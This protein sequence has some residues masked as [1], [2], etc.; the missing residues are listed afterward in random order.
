MRVRSGLSLMNP[1]NRPLTS[2]YRLFRTTPR[3]R[4]S[5]R[6]V[7]T[8]AARARGH[9]H[10]CRAP[11]PPSL[12]QLFAPHL[13]TRSA[14]LL[15]RCAGTTTDPLCC[16][17]LRARPSRWPQAAPGKAGPTCGCGRAPPLPVWP[18][19]VIAGDHA[20]GIGRNQPVASSALRLWKRKR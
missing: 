17:R 19:I 15:R 12:L 8:A 1:Q 5:T 7:G 9:G 11:L 6:A 4:A 16:R 3:I 13:P 2:S 14:G 18:S 10:R 20:D